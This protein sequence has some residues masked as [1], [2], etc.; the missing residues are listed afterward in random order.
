MTFMIKKISL[1]AQLSA[2]STDE[3]VLL[4]YFFF[5]KAGHLLRYF[6]I[7]VLL[8]KRRVIR[9]RPANIGEPI[10]SSPTKSLWLVGLSCGY[11]SQRSPVQDCIQPIPTFRYIQTIENARQKKGLLI[12]NR[13]KV[14]GA[15]K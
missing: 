14:E 15:F 7:F 4:W 11:T 12:Y 6:S 9:S 10:C 5:K 8:K 13:L 2:L 1:A 3:I